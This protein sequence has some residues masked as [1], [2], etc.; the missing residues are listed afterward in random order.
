MIGKPLVKQQDL[1]VEFT[2]WK[3]TLSWVYDATDDNYTTVIIEQC[4][5]TEEC[6]HYDVTHNTE[7]IL[8]VS[9]FVGDIFYLVIYQDGLEALQRQR[10]SEL[11]ETG[12][13]NN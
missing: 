7:Q 5:K 9:V 3:A 2:G 13:N 8:E 1:S 12:N 6:I 11:A 10:F 4:N